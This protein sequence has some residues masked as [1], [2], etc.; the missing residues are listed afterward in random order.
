[1]PQAMARH[2]HYMAHSLDLKPGIKVL[3]VG[4]GIGGPAKEIATFVDCKVVGLN[5]NAYQIEKGKEIAQKEEVGEDVLELVEGDFM[6]CHFI[7]RR[8]VR[9]RLTAGHKL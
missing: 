9:Q 5:I 2:E 6:V 7:V 3:D 1:M 8:R 4:C